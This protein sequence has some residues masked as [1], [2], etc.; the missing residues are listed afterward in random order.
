MRIQRT[1]GSA[2]QSVDVYIFSGAMFIIGLLL[3]IW[4]AVSGSIICYLIGGALC[5]FGLF[6]IITYFNKSVEEGIVQRSFVKGLATL[7]GGIVLIVRPEI[8][9]AILPILFGCILVIGGIYKLQTAL[10]LMRLG[11]QH[12][13]I[14]AIAAVIM[15]VIGVISIINPFGA[16]FALMRFIGIGLMLEGISDVAAAMTL[17]KKRKPFSEE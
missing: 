2:Q 9:V 6:C 15:C 12:W 17:S 11:Y 14:S 1:E 10:D 7:V 13:Y 3:L 4:P 5:V 16:L 8:L